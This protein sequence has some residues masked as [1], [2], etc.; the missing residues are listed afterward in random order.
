MEY[1]V[2]DVQERTRINKAGEFERYKQVTFD[3]A[4]SRHTV[5]IEPDDYKAGKMNDV[6]ATEAKKILAVLAPAKK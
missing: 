6:V 5:D 1:T 3:V 2:V 4:G